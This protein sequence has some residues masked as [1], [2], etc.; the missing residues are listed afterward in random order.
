MPHRTME[1]K[2]TG[3]SD[4]PPDEL[5]YSKGVYGEEILLTDSDEE[6]KELDEELR[7]S[8]SEWWHICTGLGQ[9]WKW[10]NT[11]N[12]ISQVV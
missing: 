11:L 5:Y 8:D 3:E 10:S 6:C 7:V 2:M 4:F 1:R 12:Q 9:V